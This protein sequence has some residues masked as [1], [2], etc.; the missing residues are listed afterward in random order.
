[1]NTVPA[2]LTEEQIGVLM[3]LSQNF[4]FAKHAVFQAPETS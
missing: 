4:E 1:M 2:Q 3:F